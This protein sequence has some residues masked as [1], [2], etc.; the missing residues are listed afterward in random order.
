MERMHHEYLRAWMAL[1]FYKLYI[2]SE[3]DDPSHGAAIYEADLLLAE[4][5]R[6]AKPVPWPADALERIEWWTGNSAAWQERAET[7]WERIGEAGA[8]IVASDATI[9]R[10]NAQLSEALNRLATSDAAKAGEPKMPGWI[11][12]LRVA[13]TWTDRC[14]ALEAWGRQGWDA[15][16]V[17]RVKLAEAQNHVVSRP[18]AEHLGALTER[19]RII[20]LLDQDA[21]NQLVLR[22]GGTDLFG[23]RLR[24]ALTPA[25]KP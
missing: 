25:V 7:A 23:V 1:E 22:S 19:N 12:P 2:H 13:E 21:P 11:G 10:L 5:D 18:E 6:T 4:L 15:A 14:E 24:D 9:A 20:A 3:T 16:A 17:L 8:H